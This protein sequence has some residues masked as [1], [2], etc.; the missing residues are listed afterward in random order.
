MRRKV[1]CF[2]GLCLIFTQSKLFAL[3]QKELEENIKNYFALNFSRLRQVASSYP[4][5][6]NFREIM[7]P[8]A[9]ETEGFFGASL[10]SPDFIILQVYYPSHFLARGYDLKKVKELEYFYKLMQEN[11]QPQL[12]EPAGGGPLN[13]RLIAMRY[14]IVKEKKLIGVV[15]MMVREEAFLKAVGLD[16]VKAFRIICLGKLAKEKG[17]LLG[18]YK[19]I[20]LLLPSTEW[21]IQYQD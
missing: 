18:E 17:K 19:E 6:N 14:P 13:P 11:P 3:T 21:I 2:L 10:I 1:F 7:K 9:E 8:V 4:Q 20:K 5:P 12:S 16:K 15:S